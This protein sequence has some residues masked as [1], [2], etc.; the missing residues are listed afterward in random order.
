MNL[1]EAIRE[2]QKEALK[3]QIRAN[4]I[5]INKS[6]AVTNQF[7]VAIGRRSGG[8]VPPMIMGMRMV[9]T[10]N[11]LPE[12]YAFAITEVDEAQLMTE[13]EKAIRRSEREKVLSEFAEKAKG[14]IKGLNCLLDEDGHSILEDTLDKIDEL[15][16][17]Y[18]QQ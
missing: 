10:E 12:E 3:R 9:L 14:Y 2:A 16:T 17:E 1:L 15:V 13:Q 11:E 7:A 4:T 8:I 5:F 18:L 6:F